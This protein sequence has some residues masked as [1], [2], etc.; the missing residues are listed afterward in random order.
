MNEVNYD[1]AGDPV[2]KNGP[3]TEFPR[4]TGVERKRYIELID[5]LRLSIHNLRKKRESI[6]SDA[7]LLINGVNQEIAEIETS[8]ADLFNECFEKNQ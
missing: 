2:R 6:I 5:E 7:D 8:L 1:M 4:G 3:R